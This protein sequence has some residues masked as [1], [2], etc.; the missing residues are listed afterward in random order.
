M[1]ISGISYRFYNGNLNA[2]STNFTQWS[3]TLKQLVRK[4]LRNCLTVFDHFV[5]LAL[6]GLILAIKRFISRREKP[7]FL[8]SD[9][10][11]FKGV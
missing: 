10:I 5:G 3:N 9:N 2:L 7:D 11:H 6:K 1:Y 4:L 8:I